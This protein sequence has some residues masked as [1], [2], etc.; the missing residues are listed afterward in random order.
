MKHLAVLCSLLFAGCVMDAE[1]ADQTGDTEQA[2]MQISP[3]PSPVQPPIAI[4]LEANR[5][6]PYTVGS[7]TDASIWPLNHNISSVEVV[8]MKADPQGRSTRFLAFVIWNGNFVARIFSSPNGTVGSSLQEVISDTLL[9]RVTYGSD[10]TAIITGGVTGGPVV[11]L[12]HPNTDGGYTFTSSYLSS[13]KAQ[14]VA[15]L[16][17]TP[18]FQFPGAPIYTP[19]E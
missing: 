2:E 7:V 13:V 10:H 19:S 17:A 8:Y 4:L 12:P 5:S 11:P 15:A 1:G 3:Q 18:V 6:V 16:N 14:A 9:E